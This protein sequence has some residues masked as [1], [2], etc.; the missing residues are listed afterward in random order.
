MNRIQLVKIFDT[1]FKILKYRWN[2]T[3]VGYFTAK[4]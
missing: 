1:P 4:R 2:F 3:H